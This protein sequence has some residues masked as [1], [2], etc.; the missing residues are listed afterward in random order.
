[1]KTI[2]IV[3]HAKSSWENY[4]LS[5]HDRPLL[6]MGVRR[7]RRVADFLNSKEIK[8]DLFI[9][10]TAR[11]AFDTAKLIAESLGYPVDNIKTVKNLYLGSANAIFSELYGLPEKVK[12]VMIFGHN[13]AFTYFVND[14]LDTT[15]E[16]LPT[17]GTVSI[18][19]ETDKWEEIDNVGFRVNF[20]VTPKMLKKK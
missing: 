11:R 10:S 14:F 7:T 17:T 20:I 18:S 13:P 1:M 16:N 3:R 9:S 2:Y 4:S 6:E 15:I 8:A 5:D 19:F 12:S